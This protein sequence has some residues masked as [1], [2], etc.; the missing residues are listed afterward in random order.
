MKMK[1]EF[2][3]TKK[4]LIASNSQQNIFALD[5][6]GNI[7]RNNLTHTVNYNGDYIFKSLPKFKNPHEKN[8]VLNSKN[9]NNNQTVSVK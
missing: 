9:Y 8:S 6:I 2:S 4:G 3:L 1:D 5:I 7:S